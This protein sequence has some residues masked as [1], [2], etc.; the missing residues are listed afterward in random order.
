MGGA[1][2]LD[3]RRRKCERIVGREER[4]EEEDMDVKK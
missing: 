1:P 2:V 4:D 3:G